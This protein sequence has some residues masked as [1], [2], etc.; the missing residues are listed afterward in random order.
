[1]MIV[2]GS[3]MKGIHHAHFAAGVEIRDAAADAKRQTIPWVERRNVQTGE[4]KSY[5][6]KGT[7]PEQVT[8]LP[9]HVM[10]VSIATT[11]PRT[12]SRCRTASTALALGC[13]RQPCRSSKSRGWR[14]Y[15][16][17]TQAPR[18]RRE[19]P[20]AIETYYKQ[21]YPQLYTQR[22]ADIETAA[23]HP[24]HLQPQCFPDLNVTCGPTP[25]TSATRTSGPSLPRRIA[26]DRDGKD[27]ITQDCGVCHQL[28]VMAQLSPDILKTLGLW[29]HI[30]A[31][32]G[33]EPSGQGADRW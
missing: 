4:T 6:A 33:A 8:S 23:R 14:R 30:E 16:R 31:L 28:R 5:F 27:A 19:I 20:A 26:H 3:K 17:V 10:H 15:R 9:K 24:R 11:G 12:P 21:A 29:D 1:M 18:T 32:K 22:K 7:T 2:G 13:C 25:T